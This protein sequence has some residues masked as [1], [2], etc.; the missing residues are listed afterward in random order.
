MLKA[1]LN[2]GFGTVDDFCLGKMETGVSPMDRK[3]A[4]VYRIVNF[5]PLPA[6]WRLWGLK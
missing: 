1:C 6:G 5:C 4:A 3:K 2:G